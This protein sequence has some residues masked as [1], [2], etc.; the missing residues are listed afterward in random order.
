MKKVNIILYFVIFLSFCHNDTFD[1]RLIMGEN[2]SKSTPIHVYYIR[3]ADLD[4]S[5]AAIQ[6]I[7]GVKQGNTSYFYSY[8]SK[9]ASTTS[10]P[11]DFPYREIQINDTFLYPQDLF[12]QHKL[13]IQD[14]TSTS[15]Q[16][17]DEL[18][19]M[20]G[21]YRLSM[22]NSTSSIMILYDDQSGKEIM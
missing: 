14:M 2:F 1:N 6:W 19:L 9:G 16:N 18:E 10:W 8:S 3:G 5:A 11:W 7:F 22:K 17:L 15:S 20:D 13:F 12:N 4:S 21:T